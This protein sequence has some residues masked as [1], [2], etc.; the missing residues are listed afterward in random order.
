MEIIAE[1]SGAEKPMAMAPA[2]GISV[3]AMTVKVCET[4]CESPRATCAPGLAVANTPHPCVGSTARAQTRSELI[5]RN[6]MVS[7]MG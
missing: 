2:I 1:N 5:E 7:P 4:D 3:R 6:A